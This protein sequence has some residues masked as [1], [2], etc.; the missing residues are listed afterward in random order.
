MR[1]LG[2]CLEVNHVG[3]AL[4][5]EKLARKNEL[6]LA[7]GIRERDRWRRGEEMFGIKGRVQMERRR[8]KGEKNCQVKVDK[9]STCKEEDEGVGKNRK[10]RVKVEKG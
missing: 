4:G 9:G 7:L 5:L 2:A 10:Q 8:R 3:G 6:K 1:H